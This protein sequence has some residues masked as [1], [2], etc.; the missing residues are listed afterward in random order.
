[1]NVTILSVTINTKPTT[2]GSYQEAD[3]A[4]KNN[5]FQGKVEGK[6]IMSFGASK[7]AFEV[8]SEGTAGGKTYEV[9]VVKND[10]GYNDWVDMKEASV[11]ASTSPSKAPTSG[12]NPAPRSNYETPEE[13]AQRQVLIVRQSSLSAAISTIGVGAKGV[14]P[15]DVLALADQY[16]D[17]VFQRK[18]KGASGFDDIPDFPD[19]FDPKVE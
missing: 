11:D 15:A 18:S 7:K 4:Y 6:K 2:R 13:R 9:T 3:V 8:L 16:S 12:A 17:W 19:D 1:M 14:K 5:T 10:K